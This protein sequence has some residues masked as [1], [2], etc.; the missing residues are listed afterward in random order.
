MARKDKEIK[1]ITLRVFSTNKSAIDLYKKI[2]FKVVARLPKRNYYKG[3]YVDDL[4]MDY[5]LR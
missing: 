1:I 4:V 3:K 5:Y 2:G